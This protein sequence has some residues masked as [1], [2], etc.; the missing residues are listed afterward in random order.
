MSLRTSLP[1]SEIDQAIAAARASQARWLRVAERIGATR[2]AQLQAGGI[3]N[4]DAKS[5]QHAQAMAA[6]YAA[7]LQLLAGVRTAWL[8]SEP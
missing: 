5:L 3:W 4:R 7:E 6:H 1:L 8:N 2:H